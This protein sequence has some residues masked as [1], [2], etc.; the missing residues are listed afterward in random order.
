VVGVR[1][2]RYLEARPE[3]QLDRLELRQLREHPVAALAA[4]EVLAALGAQH[5]DAPAGWRRRLS[6]ET[7][8]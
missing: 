5:H 1:V 7:R 3:P 6:H 2:R 4:R 8:L